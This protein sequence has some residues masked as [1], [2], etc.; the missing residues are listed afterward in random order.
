[1]SDRGEAIE[2]QINRELAGA[3]TIQPHGGGMTA[4]AIQPK[5]MGD[6]M[7]FAKLMSVSGVC[8]R[9]PFRGNPGACLAIVLQAMK[10]G[11]DPFAVANKAFIVNDQ[12]SYESQLINAIVNSSTM[13]AKRLDAV[14]EGTGEQRTCR[15]TGVIKGESEP[16]EYVS[17]PIGRI[18]IKNSPLWKGDP[19][20][21]LY[22]YSSRAWARRWVPE[23]LLGIYTVDELSPVVELTADAPRVRE[24]EPRSQLEQFEE[25]HGDTGEALM[26]EAPGPAASQPPQPS[27][28]E[29]DRGPDHLMPV[30]PPPPLDRAALEI[31]PVLKRGGQP[32]WRT[33][34]NVLLAPKIRHCAS[35]NDLAELLGANEQHLEAA[36]APGAMPTEDLTEL[37]RLIAEQWQKLPG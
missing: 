4:Y 14:F 22:Y 27:T 6:V 34:A 30:E 23:V 31:A 3:I 18:P 9:Q 19:D 12:L 11:A 5:S 33:W 17:P 24:A 25:R 10:W 32:D 1:M 35:S 36:R 37:E 15:V 13:L 28:E 26:Q 29:P 2:R 7:E 20:Q 21:Q 16:R 8:I